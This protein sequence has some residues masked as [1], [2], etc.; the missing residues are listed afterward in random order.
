MR[1]LSVAGFGLAALLSVAVATTSSA[2]TVVG[3]GVGG[4]VAMPMGDFGDA[5]KMGFGGGA[6]LF[7]YPNGG[8]IGVRADVGY[9][10]FDAENDAN[11]K[12][13]QLSAMGNLLFAIPTD[14][15]LRPYLVAGAGMLNSKADVEGAESSSAFAFQGGAGVSVGSGNARFF[16]EGKFVTSSK[17]GNTTSYIPILA[18]VSY[19]FR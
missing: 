2:Q 6:G 14:A 11:P 3:V 17:D 9:L 4:G 10:Q 19:R 16:V 18:G 8:N 12:V 13:K 15:N 5:A 1:K 7:I